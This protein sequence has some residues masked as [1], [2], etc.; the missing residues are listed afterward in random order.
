MAN[1]VRSRCAS[2]PATELGW[3][4]SPCTC[5]ADDARCHVSRP[6]TMAV[7]LTVRDRPPGPDRCRRRWPR[8]MAPIPVPSGI[9]IPQ[10][11]RRIRGS[12]CRCRTHLRRTRPA[13]PESI[14]VK[15]GERPHV[16]SRRRCRSWLRPNPASTRPLRSSFS[17]AAPT[18]R[19]IK[20]VAG[21]GWARH[22]SGGPHADEVCQV[23]RM[24]GRGPR[25]VSATATFSPRNCWPTRYRGAGGGRTRNWRC[26]SR[27][28]DGDRDRSVQRRRQKLIE[29]APA[30]WLADDLRARQHSAA[31]RLCARNGY[32]GWPTRLEFRRW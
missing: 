16:R 10:W 23:F 12:L 6:A 8:Q 9:R 15:Q 19:A 3:T 30:Q 17:P 7:A 20:A 27:S 25:R 21:G 28:G 18:A 29:V 2:S 32:R 13:D 11:G 1:R 5:C 14:S 4:Q 24:C 26:D 22:A 31:N